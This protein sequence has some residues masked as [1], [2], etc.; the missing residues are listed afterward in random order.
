MVLAT[1]MSL[2]PSFTPL[3]ADPTVVTCFHCMAEQE[4][5]VNAVSL[6]C[7]RCGKAIDIGSYEI[8]HTNSREIRTHGEV[9]I[10]TRAK[11]VGSFLRAGRLVVWG[12]LDAPFDC[13][14]FVAGKMAFVSSGGT[15]KALH[16]LPGARVRFQHPLTVEQ[17]YISG[18]LDIE[19]LTVHNE[20][21]IKRG[22]VL[23][24]NVQTS[25][26]HVERGASY[27]GVLTLDP[28][29]AIP[30]PP[31]PQPPHAEPSPKTDPS[32]PQSSD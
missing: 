1:Q 13:K 8:D 4:V 29:L 25:T 2:P 20:L 17:A 21:V 24:A 11:Y 6:H 14:E 9:Q 15:A 28:E 27:E 32:P 16:I 19:N 7:S 22:G 3:F 31:P 18:Q 23:N 10:G 30:E 5:P 26:I 12:V